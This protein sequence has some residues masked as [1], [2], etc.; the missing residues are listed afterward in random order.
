MRN[1]LILLAP[2]ALAGCL[3]TQM[4]DRCASYGHFQGAP[5]FE[6]CMRQELAIELAKSQQLTAG[7]LGAAAIYSS[8]YPAY[9]GLPAGA[10]APTP[11]SPAIRCSQQGVYWTCQ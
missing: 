9:S 3:Q 2:V 4:T 7:L 1:F 10:W 5:D 11:P 6:P 8:S